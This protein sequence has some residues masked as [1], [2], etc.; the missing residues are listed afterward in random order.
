ML[1]FICSCDNKNNSGVILYEDFPST[2]NL[3]GKEIMLNDSIYF[4]YPE[5]IVKDSICCILDSN[6]PNGYFCYVFTFPDFKYKY[7]LGAKG[8][9]ANELIL[10]YEAQIIDNY[11]YI[12]DVKK[13]MRYDLNNP[14]HQPKEAF[15]VKEHIYRSVIINDSI[16]AGSSDNHPLQ[17][18]QLYNRDGDVIKHLL[19]P[20]ENVIKNVAFTPQAVWCSFIRYDKKTNCLFLAT[21]GGEVIDR[22]N[23]DSEEHISSIGPIGRPE[24]Y[25]KDGVYSTSNFQGFGNF[26][27][28]DNKIYALFSGLAMD[29]VWKEDP[30]HKNC[31]QVYDID[32]NPLKR[33]TFDRNLISFYVDKLNR[34]IY[35]TDTSSEFMLSVY[36]F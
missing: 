19:P 8:N 12:K 22:I 26:G 30:S 28:S 21:T 18:I 3:K 2:E 33:Y 7:R 27:I 29:E 14:T 5:L 32:G 17:R 9:A 10:A 13:I 23:L 15:K 6:A 1:I 11:L 35:A 34:K 31:M 24:I 25:H 36:D 16:Y 4:T 20:I